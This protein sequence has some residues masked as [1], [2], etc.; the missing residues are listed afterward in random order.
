MQALAEARARE[1]AERRDLILQLRALMGPSNRSSGGGGSRA[2]GRQVDETAVAE[3][4]INEQMSLLELRE[5]LV[6][7]QRQRKEEVRRAGAHT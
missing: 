1:I 4:G 3:L 6:V 7:L 2:G 5:R